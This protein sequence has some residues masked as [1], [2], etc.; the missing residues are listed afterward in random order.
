MNQSVPQDFQFFDNLNEFNFS[1]RTL[2]HDDVSKSV[3]ITEAQSVRDDNA[4]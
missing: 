3:G 1:I 2:N 4:G